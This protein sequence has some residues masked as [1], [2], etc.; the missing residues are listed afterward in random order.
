MDEEACLN[1]P[2]AR[3]KSYVGCPLSPREREC[4]LW[5]ARGKTY[6]DIGAI[7]GIA[8]GT[9]KTNLDIARYKLNCMTL[10]HATATA[11]ARG[12]FTLADLES[13]T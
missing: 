7:L 9:V 11:V 6:N 5:A 2:V 8:Y 3:A 4:L 13:R 12:I 1:W 10:A